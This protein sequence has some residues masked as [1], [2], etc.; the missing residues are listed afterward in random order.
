MKS[1]DGKKLR[2]ETSSKEEETTGMVKERGKKEEEEEDTPVVEKDEEELVAKERRRLTS[3]SQSTGTSNNSSVSLSSQYSTRMSTRRVL[4]RERH[5][6]TN[7]N[8]R[9]ELSLRQSTSGSANSG[10]VQTKQ[11]EYNRQKSV[12]EVQEKE[13]GEE[14]S[15]RSTEQHHD[16]TQNIKLP[17]LTDIERKH[18]EKAFEKN[19]SIAHVGF[20][21]LAM[22]ALISGIERRTYEKHQIIAK[23]KDIEE[24]FVVLVKGTAMSYEDDDNMRIADDQGGKFSPSTKEKNTTVLKEGSTWA[25]GAMVEPQV[26]ARLLVANS[27]EG[28]EVIKIHKSHFER[29]IKTVTKLA[30]TVALRIFLSCQRTSEAFDND[31]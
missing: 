16:K 5:V 8:N 13:N 17:L 20:F 19:A 22:E 7:R 11:K 14:V 28:A 25:E 4:Q 3:S 31:T 1:D 23:P 12:S 2:L 15:S 24:S 9:S 29:A 18:L 21:S 26:N 27:E 6:S 10:S 30:A